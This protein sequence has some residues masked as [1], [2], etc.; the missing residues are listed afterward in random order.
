M[1]KIDFGKVMKSVQKFWD[2]PPKGKFLNLKE[3]L[4]LGTASLGVSC[5]CNIISIY[6]TVGYLP[7][8]YNMGN[9]G[10]MHATIMYIVAFAFGMIL[11]PIYGKMVQK[12][13]TKFGRYKPYILFVAPILS[14][15]AVLA[16]WSPQGMSQTSNIIYMYLTCTPTIIVW[17]LWFNTFNMFPGV[18]T[19]N[20]QE[21]TDIWSPIGLVMGLAPTIMN[22]L[23]G[24]FA[25]I[26]GDVV[27]ARVFSI[28]SVIIGL[29][30]VILLIKV[31]ERVF[32]TEE[33][34]QKESISMFKSLT[35][36]LK[37]KPLMILALALI[38]GSMK[39]TID[40]SY[41]LI[42]RVKYATEVGDAAAI[43]GGL[44]L[45]VGFAATPNM[46]LLPW[47]TRKF[48]NKTIMMFWQACNILGLAIFSII[49]FQN[50]EQSTAS[51]AIITA[52]RFVA[53]FNAIGSL[54]PLMLSEIGDYQQNKTG[55]RLDGFIQTIAYSV[56]TFLS[57]LLM[58]I[59]AVI[60]GKMG[61]NPS[62]YQVPKEGMK[63]YLTPELIAT[64]D[65][66]FN[67]ATYIS[68]ASSI[69]M[70]ICLIFYPLSKKKHAQIVEE[71]KSK[72]VNSDEILSEQG[73]KVL[74]DILVDADENNNFDANANDETNGEAE[75]IDNNSEVNEK[76][77]IN[78]DIVQN[79]ESDSLNSEEDEVK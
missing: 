67:V 78:Y 39:G 56:V 41:E 23:K 59:P 29:L 52:L 22:A 74:F 45:I 33:E 71:L 16:S 13:K 14:L 20:Q 61:L 17:N 60:Q 31:K 4:S 69:L 63:S 19:P 55:Y 46:L 65:G 68:L 58:L 79:S 8:L 66:Y 32:V 2:T 36:V 53:T 44:S 27:A 49:G 1:K 24:V 34:K 70:F 40:M 51:A 37:N 10:T 42:G 25:K 7:V 21:R 50:F 43:F 35:M 64:A 48:N 18:F 3:I 26:W 15:F 11:T 77:E 6:I 9:F 28:T 76:S 57:N 38:C 5:I 54:Q 72:S 47:L 30:C 75:D 62:N 12:T 73:D